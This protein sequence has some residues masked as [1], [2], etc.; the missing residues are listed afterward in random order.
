MGGDP[1]NAPPNGALERGRNDIYIFI[2]NVYANF[3]KD[4]LD[5]FSMHMWPRFEYRVV[6]TYDKAV[7]YLTKKLAECRELDKPLLPALILNP[8]GEFEWA[9][10]I[11][12]GHQLWRF[13]NLAPGM[14]KRIFDPV[15]QDAHT[16]VN[17]GFIRMQG[18][19]ELLMLLNSFYE[20]CDVRMM[21]MQ[22]FGGFDR[23]IY[24]QF[25]TS[26]I[27]LPDE[28][29]NYRYTNPYTGL[30]YVLDWKKA[31]AFE[32]LIKTTARDE[33]VLPVEIKPIYKMTAVGDNSERYGGTDRLADWRLTAT[34][35]YEI[36]IPSYFM[37]ESDY[38]AE[39]VHMELR[40]GSAYTDYPTNEPPVPVNRFVEAVH[41]DW[42]LDSTSDS[43]INIDGDCGQADRALTLQTRYYYFVT[44]ADI[45]SSTSLVI[46]IPEQILDK[47]LL[48]VN[49]KYGLLSYGDHYILID[50]GNAI[51]IREA[52]VELEEGMVIELYVYIEGTT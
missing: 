12:G 24:P 20:F 44:Q 4:S 5:Y 3:F 45:D 34:I 42:G 37:L 7:E 48:M 30:S 23:W 49:S 11:A 50:S 39:N 6:A 38:L 27:I 22:V 35:R 36:E 18:D 19:I 25:F 21:L 1:K 43:T 52:T 14:I 33:W 9:D 15:Y 41:K 8:S 13:P 10:A 16:Q 26:F 2:H 47:D 17:V 51:E 29:L 31:G 32:K 46:Q 40:A 28:I